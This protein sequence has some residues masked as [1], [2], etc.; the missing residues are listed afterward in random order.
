MR[1][2][3]TAVSKMKINK[4]TLE[5]FFPHLAREIEIRDQGVNITS[6]RSETKR[7]EEASSRKFAGYKPDVIDFIRRCDNKKQ[8]EEILEYLENRGK[9]TSSYAKKLRKQ[10]KERGVRSFGTKKEDDYYARK[11][12]Q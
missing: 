12:H 7:G 9:I 5:K 6:V 1:A 3:K 11:V 10:L 2:S 8:A 4:K